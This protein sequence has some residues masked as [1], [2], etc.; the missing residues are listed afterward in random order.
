MRYVV[1]LHSN[2]GMSDAV[3]KIIVL[4]GMGSDNSVSYHEIC[5]LSAFECGDV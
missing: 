1:C 4:I 3:F 5:S 2:V